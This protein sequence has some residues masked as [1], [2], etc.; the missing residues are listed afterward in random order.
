M[1]WIK[2]ILFLFYLGRG[3]ERG[4]QEGQTRSLQCSLLYFTAINNIVKYLPRSSLVPS[5][6]N[7]YF[8]FKN[9]ERRS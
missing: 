7:T 5:S 1:G 8:L 9:V 4:V 6:A 2:I 3:R